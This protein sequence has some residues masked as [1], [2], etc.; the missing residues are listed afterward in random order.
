[1]SRRPKQPEVAPGPP[2]AGIA[3]PLPEAVAEPVVEVAAEPT[4]AAMA[5]PVVG[6]AA[7]P[8]VEAVA[9]PVVVA[10]PETLADAGPP[11]PLPVR[12][13]IRR[14]R[15]ADR[16]G[17]WQTFDWT[18]RP[19]ATVLDA[20]LDIRREQ[21]PSLV[22]RH[23][24]M[25]GSCGA[26]GVRVDGRETL[27]CETPASSAPGRQVTVEPLRT[28]PLVADLAVDMADFHA[29][30][31]PAGLPILRASEAPAGAAPPEGVR[32]FTRFEDCVECGLCLS[33]CPVSNADHSY[34][35]PAALAAAAR[36]VAE[37][38]GRE[39]RPLFALAKEPD[40]VWRCT[41]ALQCSVVC[42]E[43]VDPARS[44]LGLRRRVA[45]DAV[46]SFFRRGGR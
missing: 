27:A 9:E 26:C 24:C 34:I 37:P 18:P 33:A 42:P 2:F 10:V 32:G 25:H 13:R 15:P 40:S 36:V 3:P 41:D 39:L 11:S 31:E 5:E 35:G 16:E 45:F 22:V 43:A 44:L 21:D 17:R 23:S 1:M 8:M 20:L 4:V 6:V 29:R 19:G 7:E 28:Q 38:R 30:M 46:K 12:F 14:G